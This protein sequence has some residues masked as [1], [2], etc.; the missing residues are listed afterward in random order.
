MK[1][2]ATGAPEFFLIE[3]RPTFRR[4]RGRFWRPNGN[5]YTDLI[6]RAGVY[7]SRDALEIAH[8]DSEH[9][10]RLMPALRALRELGERLDVVE[11]GSTP[12]DVRAQMSRLRGE[13]PPPVSPAIIADEL[14]RQAIAMVRVERPKECSVG[15]GEC[16]DCRP[17]TP[18]VLWA[19]VKDLFG[20][21]STVSAAICRKYGF[22]PDEEFKP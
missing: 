2:K 16:E 3:V 9:K 5:G 17:P 11:A 19:R 6:E 20:H 21:G 8:G 18:R 10:T 1:S 22:D 15:C 7:S 13:V 14:V 4:G 12:D